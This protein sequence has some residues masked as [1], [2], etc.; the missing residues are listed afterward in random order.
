[1]FLGASDDTFKAGPVTTVCQ[2]ALGGIAAGDVNKDG[3]LDLVIGAQPG[4]V[5]TLL[6]NGNGSFRAPIGSNTSSSGGPIA[7]GDFNHDGRLDVATSDG[8]FVFQVLL[9][10]GDGAFLA[11]DQYD[12]PGLNQFLAADVDGDGNLDLLAAVSSVSGPDMCSV[13]YVAVLGGN[14]D[15]TFQSSSTYGVGFDPLQIELS[16]F[17]W[18]WAP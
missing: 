16:D 7:L 2:C 1:M 4:R 11:G 10:N 17:E 8:F 6:G 12:L 3:H 15:G 14:G 13:G 9:G 18:G 5:Y